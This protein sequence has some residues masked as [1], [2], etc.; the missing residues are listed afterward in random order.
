MTEGGHRGR[1]AFT[2]GAALAVLALAS[3]AC[4]ESNKPATGPSTSVPDPGVDTEEVETLLVDAQRRASPDFSVGAASCPDRVTVEEG[5]AFRCT[6][7]VEGLE[8][9]Y[10]VTLGNLNTGEQTGRFQFRPAKALLSVPRLVDFL[11]GASTD[12]AARVD[13]GPDRIK[14]VDPGTTMECNLTDGDGSHTA[15]LRVEDVQGRVTLVS[16]T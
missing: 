12:P 10:R 9:P 13:C 16:V 14:V 5:A 8:V 7:V 6:V 4:R 1:R 15:T 11:K 2:T 3:A